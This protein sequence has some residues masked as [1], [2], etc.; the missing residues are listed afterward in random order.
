MPASLHSRFA[1][2]SRTGHFTELGACGAAAN[3]MAHSRGEAA[4]GLFEANS[5]I[6]PLEK[7]IDDRCQM[8]L[9][10]PHGHSGRCWPML[11]ALSGVKLSFTYPPRAV[12]VT[13]RRRNGRMQTKR[14]ALKPAPSVKQNGVDAD[15]VSSAI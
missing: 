4:C 15:A 9:A 12:G 1:Q 6:V 14:A 3:G 8:L 5:P 10:G 11:K 2:K 13:V 7:M